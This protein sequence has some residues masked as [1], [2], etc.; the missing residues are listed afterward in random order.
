M[1]LFGTSCYSEYGSVH[2]KRS[3]IFGGIVGAGA[4][5]LIGEHNDRELEGAAVGGVI[6]AITGGVLGSARDEQYYHRS[7]PRYRSSNYNQTPPYRPYSQNYSRGYNYG[8][9][10][11]HYDRYPR[12]RSYSRSSSYCR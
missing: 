8:G 9:N 5:A 10:H 2:T 3:A 4:G 11:D 6:G 12:H 1:A 7:Q